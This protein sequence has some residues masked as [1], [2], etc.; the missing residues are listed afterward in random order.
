MART[1]AGRTLVVGAF[2]AALICG[3]GQSAS[4]QPCA[5]DCNNSGSVTINDIVRALEIALGGA[6]L[7][8]CPAADTDNDGTVRVEEI[9]AATL[10]ALGGCD[11]GGNLVPRAAGEVT[12]IIGTAIIAAG[13]SGTFDVSL[14]SGGLDVAGIQIDITFDLLTPI[15]DAGGVPDC[16]INPATG[17]SLFRAFPDTDRARFLVLSLSNVDPIPDGVLFTCNVEVASFAPANTYPLTG[18]NE[19]ASDP[20]GMALTTIAQD[21]AI[22]VAAPTP[23]GTAT[24]TPTPV[25]A[26]ACPPTPLSGC[27]TAIKSKLSLGNGQ[28][29][30]KWLQGT[31]NLGD[32][33]YPVAG[34]T[35]YT[36]CVYGS[37]ASEPSVAMRA[38]IPGN[39]MCGGTFC[40]KPT[41]VKGFKYKDTAGSADGITR[42]R[43]RAGS[44]DAKVMVK[45]NGAGLPLPPPADPNN[46]IYQ[47]PNVTVQLRNSDGV[48]W[49]AVYPGPAQRIDGSQFVDR[50]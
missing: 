49:E 15:V 25:P 30:W 13:D 16:T 3:P 42:I 47:D 37:Q 1:L 26:N 50:F 46:L 48:C 19:G 44:G 18:S 23:T 12:L 20:N 10:A 39:T 45:G 35:T 5:G 24:P 43:L 28:L 7:D 32:F 14:D 41:G 21:G 40:W 27:R 11:S 36:L 2:I 17:K 33:G 29:S 22:I 8:I 31:S 9:T 6:S 38:A 4:A 34:P